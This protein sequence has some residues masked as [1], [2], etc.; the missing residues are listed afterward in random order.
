MDAEIR[1]RDSVN[2]IGKYLA[3]TKCI[4]YGKLTGGKHGWYRKVIYN[5]RPYFVCYTVDAQLEWVY[6]DIY[7]SCMCG[8]PYR[9]QLMSYAVQK[10]S[11]LHKG[12]IDVD[13]GNGEVF[14]R[15]T[16]SINSRAVTCNEIR[17]LERVGIVE[18]AD[19]Y[20]DEISDIANGIALFGRPHESKKAGRSGL[21]LSELSSA[22][23]HIVPTD[24]P[25]DDGEDNDSDL[26]DEIMRRVDMEDNYDSEDDDKES[27]DNNWDEDEGSEDN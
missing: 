13:D 16:T 12:R 15:M 1:V 18:I 3:N 11:Y 8:A 24:K 14:I 19:K 4:C 10:T 21:P 22:E 25:K 20:F 9:R 26:E 6:V 27:R 7:L 23:V 5:S 2:N 17:A